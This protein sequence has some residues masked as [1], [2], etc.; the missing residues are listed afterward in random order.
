MTELAVLELLRDGPEPTA[1]RIIAT[2]AREHRVKV[3]DLRAG[4]ISYEVLV[5]EIFA[6]D[7][8]ICW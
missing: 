2:H 3:V 4:E 7:K 5:D 1:N 6:H 8:V